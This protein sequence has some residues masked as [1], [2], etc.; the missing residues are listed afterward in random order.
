[1]PWRASYRGLRLP[2]RVIKLRRGD[3]ERLQRLVRTP[4]SAACGRTRSRCSRSPRTQTSHSRLG[5]AV[6][7]TTRNPCSACARSQT[8]PGPFGGDPAPRQGRRQDEHE[9][10]R[11]VR[12]ARPRRS[13]GPCHLAAAPRRRSGPAPEGSSACRA[14]RVVL[15]LS[16]ALQ[17]GNRRASV[18]AENS[19][20]DR[21]LCRMSPFRLADLIAVRGNP[22]E[23][24]DALRDV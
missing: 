17:R 11:S 8:G 19:C 1:M 6:K 20:L 15:P 3:R 23:D 16:A 12:A 22:L 2:A 9:G 14:M 7:Q 18:W 21:K 13:R 10:A 5:V 4:R 24:I